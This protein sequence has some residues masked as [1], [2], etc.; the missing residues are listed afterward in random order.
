VDEIDDGPLLIEQA[1]LVLAESVEALRR[2]GAERD[3]AREQ[4]ASCL[5][6]TS[7]CV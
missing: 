6:Y 2:M 7:R 3:L 5:L 4:V 1:V